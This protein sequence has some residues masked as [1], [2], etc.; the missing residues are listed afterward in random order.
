M[1]VTVP[2]AISTWCLM[3]RSSVTDAAIPVTFIGR[4]MLRRR[5]GRAE[6]RAV[7]LCGVYKGN[8]AA[9]NIFPAS[10]HLG[11]SSCAP[12]SNS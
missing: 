4:N 7:P 11:E 1:G 9:N 8:M 5:Q 3:W 10:A 12:V 6:K 2:A